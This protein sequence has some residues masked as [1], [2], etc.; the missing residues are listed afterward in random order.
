MGLDGDPFLLVSPLSPPLP[1][2]VRLSHRDTWWGDSC[3]SFFSCMH[4]ISEDLLL[5]FGREEFPPPFGI[6]GIITFLPL[7]LTLP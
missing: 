3:R 7:Q 4:T 6:A 5:F 1:P 2:K